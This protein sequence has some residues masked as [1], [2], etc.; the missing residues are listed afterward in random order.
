[1]RRGAAAADGD[2]AGL[3][4]LWAAWEAEG[5]AFWGEMDALVSMLDDLIEKE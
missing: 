2:A 3:A 4:E 1:M 5:E